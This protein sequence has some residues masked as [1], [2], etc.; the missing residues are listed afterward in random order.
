[1][2][3]V[4]QFFFFYVNIVVGYVDH[5]YDSGRINDQYWEECGPYGIGLVAT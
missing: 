5:R 1:M 3:A 2:V 4:I